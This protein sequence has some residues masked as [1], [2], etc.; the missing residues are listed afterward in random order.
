[1]IS[2]EKIN[3]RGPDVTIKYK[4]HK[5]IQIIDMACSSDQSM[6]ILRRTYWSISNWLITPGHHVKVIWAVTECTEER[7]N[8]LKEQESLKQTKRL[9]DLKRD[10]QDC[11]LRANDNEEGVVKRHCSSLERKKVASESWWS[12]STQSAL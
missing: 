4:N 5:L 2:N 3:A 9:Q 10:A 7:A 12:S 1:M 6:R 8:S 11:L